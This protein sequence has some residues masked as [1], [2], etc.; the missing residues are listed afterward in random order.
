M[1]REQ[2]GTLYHWLLKLKKEHWARE[3][4]GM[5]DRMLMPMIKIKKCL[6]ILQSRGI[7]WFYYR[8]FYANTILRSNPVACCPDGQ[9]ELHTLV[10]ER[11]AMNAL[12]ALKTFYHFSATRPGLILYDDGS[13][14][15]AATSMFSAHFPNCR[16]IRHV[17]FHRDMEDFLKRY[18]TSLE[19]SKKKSFYCALKLFG[20]MCYSKS[21]YVL[22]MDSDILFFQ[23][24]SEMLEYIWSGTPFY[25]SDYQDAYSYPIEFLKNLMKSD[26]A[27]KVN[28]GFSIL[29]GKTLPAIWIQWNLTL[30]TFRNSKSIR[31]Q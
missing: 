10:C 11:D 2:T 30:K 16:I 9:F 7:R 15:V 3:R 28:T 19:Y 25:M 1:S 20:P 18:R 12:W 17:D 31:P 6:R 27:H 24:P 14:S 5:E 26:L 8:T 4:T 21:E 23:K 29:P 22:C 13:L